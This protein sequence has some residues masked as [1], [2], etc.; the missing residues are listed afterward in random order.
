MLL[1]EEY[2]SYT[3]F[4]TSLLVLETWNCRWEN[5]LYK[6]IIDPLVGC[7]I[8]KVQEIVSLYENCRKHQQ[9]MVGFPERNNPKLFPYVLIDFRV[10]E[11]VK[12]VECII[13]SFLP[14]Q[15]N[16]FATWAGYNHMWS[17]YL[18]GTF[19]FFLF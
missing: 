14:L 4:E 15:S 8:K 16:R 1:T 11:P 3:R 5:T 18:W 7:P 9:R 2:H 19:F 6:E 10:T 13:L 12:V 17:P